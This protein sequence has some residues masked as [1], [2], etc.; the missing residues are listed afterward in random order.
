MSL[1]LLNVEASW[2]GLDSPVIALIP[3]HQLTVIL[4]Y[5]EAD[6]PEHILARDQSQRR[7]EGRARLVY[8]T[9]AELFYMLS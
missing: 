9:A 6:H 4:L 5:Q 7:V 2:A 1:H 3:F 8:I